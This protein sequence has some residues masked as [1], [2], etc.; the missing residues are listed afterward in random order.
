MDLSFIQI[1]ESQ[2][3]GSSPVLVKVSDA[4][5]PYTDVNVNFEDVFS[6]SFA[7]YSRGWNMGEPIK[8]SSDRYDNLLATVMLPVAV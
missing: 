4:Q 5:V 3:Y 2:E 7:L 8:E 1:A 6:I